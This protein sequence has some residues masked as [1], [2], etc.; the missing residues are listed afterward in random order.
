M[1]N[2]CVNF[3]SVSVSIGLLFLLRPRGDFLSPVKFDGTR[4][5]VPRI[6]AED[7]RPLLSSLIRGT[8][9]TGEVDHLLDFAIIGRKCICLFRGM[10]LFC[11]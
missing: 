6:R 3:V 8:N 9:V 7:R 4:R 11:W 5:V 1:R 2:C 10:V